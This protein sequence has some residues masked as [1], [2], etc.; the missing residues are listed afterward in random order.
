MSHLQAIRRFTAPCATALLLAATLGAVSTSAARALTS[1]AKPAESAPVREL[2][3]V[4]LVTFHIGNLS[5][6]R[7]VAVPEIGEVSVMEVI[8]AGGNEKFVLQPG[9]TPAEVFHRLAPRNTP[10]PEA[11]LASDDRQLLADRALVTAIDAPIQVRPAKLGLKPSLPTKVGGGSCQNGAAGADYFID[12]HCGALGGPGYGSSES[13][14]DSDASDWIQRT[15][16]STRRATYTRMAS[17]G[18]GDNRLRHFYHTVIDGWVTQV[19][20]VF[21]PG[22]VISWWSYVTGI[23]RDRRVRFEEEESAGW[24]RGWTKYHS[25]VADGW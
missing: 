10:V 11:I 6:V 5:E 1:G 2:E 7:I 17:C 8:P 4:R 20:E 23:K 14:C 25:E 3:S 15:S 16:S 19:N 22:Q 24:V 21:A 18:D 13:Y 9:L 12:N